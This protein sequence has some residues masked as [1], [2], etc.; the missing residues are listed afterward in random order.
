MADKDPAVRLDCLRPSRSGRRVGAECGSIPNKN[1]VLGHEYGSIIACEYLPD[2]AQFA[3]HLRQVGRQGMIGRKPL[4]GLVK[5]ADLVHRPD[6]EAPVSAESHG[7]DRVTSGDGETGP[8]L[9][10]EGKHLVA[11]EIKF[12]SVVL[13]CRPAD[14][15]DSRVPRRVTGQ[16]QAALLATSRQRKRQGRTGCA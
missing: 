8:A 5:V 16:Y 15:C 4:L 1:R 12:A 10:I 13:R 3:R 6:P 2:I 7:A 14:S 9:A 11:A